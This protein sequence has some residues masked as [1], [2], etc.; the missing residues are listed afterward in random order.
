MRRFETT[1]I[2]WALLS[3]GCAATPGLGGATS[4]IGAQESSQAALESE[5]AVPQGDLNP[6][7][8]DAAA[9]DARGRMTCRQVLRPGSNVIV[10]RCFTEQGWEKYRR[11]QT[12][13]AQETL[14]T[15][16]GG[17]FR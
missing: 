7:A 1:L 8:V 3:A 2:L 17:G 9:L 13:Y 16:Q 11:R 12:I 15:M 4:Q 10:E 14:R 5:Q 6:I